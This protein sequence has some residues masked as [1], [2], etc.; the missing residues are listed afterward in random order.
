MLHVELVLAVDSILAVPDIVQL[1]VDRLHV[2]VALIL[3]DSAQEHHQGKPQEHHVLVLDN[4]H[5]VYPKPHK[6]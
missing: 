3:E 2:V 4:D 5:L 1:V 6:A